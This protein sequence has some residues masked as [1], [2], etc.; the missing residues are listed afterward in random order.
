MLI[1]VSIELG[2]PDSGHL[3]KG[4]MRS[5]VAGCRMLPLVAISKSSR[6][7]LQSRSVICSSRLS[8]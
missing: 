2:R 6:K 8:E 7:I 5:P 1:A 3:R 4:M